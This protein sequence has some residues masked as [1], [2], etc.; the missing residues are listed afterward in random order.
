[1]Q[2]SQ[3]R[4]LGFLTL[5]YTVVILLANWFDS[6]LIKVFGLNT[7][8]GTLI[9]PLTFLLSDLI[10]EVYGFKRARRAIWCGLLFN[11]IFIL[12]GQLVIHLPSP[13]YPTNNAMFDTI[14]G[15]NLRIVIASTISYLTSE[16]LNSVILAKLKIRAQGR[17]MSVRFVFS[18]LIA[19]GVDSTLFSVIAFYGLMSTADLASLILTMWFIKIAIEIIG[20]PISIKLANTLKKVEQLDIYDRNTDFTLFKLEDSYARSANEYT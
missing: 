8:A 12:Y 2:T 7:D 18:T 20:L 11:F 15:M 5:S 10:T 13:D 14:M 16:P 1:M 4:Y 9:F 19:S 17:Y 3:L 6:R